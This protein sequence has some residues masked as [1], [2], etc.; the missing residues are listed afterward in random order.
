MASALDYAHQQ[1]LIHRD[2]KP[3]NMLLGPQDQVLLSDFGLVVVARNTGSL[4]T[5]PMVGTVLY[6]APEQLEGKVYFASDQYALGVVTYEWLCG[7]CPFT[8]S[9]FIQVGTQHI[10]ASPPSLCERVPDLPP[11][12]ERVVFK[13]LAKDPAQRYKNVM[14]FADAFL[15]ASCKDVRSATINGLTIQPSSPSLK[16]LQQSAEMSRMPVPVKPIQ[17]SYSLE[18]IWRIVLLILT[19]LAV[20]AMWYTV[21]LHKG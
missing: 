14:A 10:V 15:Q 4:P 3:E 1:R 9:S 16:T 12:V 19:I 8:G 5:N 11:A 7:Q 13:A 21:T 6:M 20:I 18:D 2:V 17:S